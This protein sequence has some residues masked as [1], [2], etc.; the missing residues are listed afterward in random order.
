V[1]LYLFIRLLKYLYLM[2]SGF[3]YRREKQ[4]ERER[5]RE[6]EGKEKGRE[7]ERRGQDREEILL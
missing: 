1:K 3:L 6:R 5:G 2:V 4:R 7:G